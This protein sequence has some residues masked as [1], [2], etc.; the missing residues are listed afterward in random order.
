MIF[1]DCIVI[2]YFLRNIEQVNYLFYF[3]VNFLGEG[4]CKE[5][6]KLLIEGGLVKLD[7]RK[8]N[9]ID[10]GLIFVIRVISVEKCKFQRLSFGLNDLISLDVLVYFCKLL[11]IKS[12][13]F[14]CL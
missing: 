2:V 4:G 13:K 7:L 14:I 3:G 8:N 10:W 12:C 5:L 11:K 6:V 1:V 9:L